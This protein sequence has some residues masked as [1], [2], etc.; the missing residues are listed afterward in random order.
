[1]SVWE[2]LLGHPRALAVVKNAAARPTGSYLLV[3]APGG[4]KRNAARVLA[5]ALICPEGCG[6]CN[7]CSRVLRDLH[8]DVTVLQPEGYTFAVE[9]LRAAAAAAA[10]TP[11]EAAHR[12]FLVEEADRIP[13]RTQNALLKA[14]EEPNA[15]VV[16]ILLA[17]STEAF[18]PTI[19]SRCQMIDFPPVAEEALAK[20]L[21]SR[22]SMS[23]QASHL[24][25]RAS[26]G[27]LDAAVRL[28]EDTPADALRRRALQ[29]C[30]RPEPSGA[31]LLREAD[32]I[33]AL[34]TSFR[35]AADKKLTAEIADFEKVAGPQT[36]AWRKRMLD[37]NKRVLRRLE[38][39]V[40]IDYLSWLGGAFRDLAAASSGA[41][42][43][44][45]I[46]HDFVEGLQ[47]AS[48]SHGTGFWIDMVERCLNG[49]LAI[50]EN[51]NPTLVTESILLRLVGFGSSAEGLP[52]S[53]VRRR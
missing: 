13:E 1:M 34:A 14:L 11:L 52:M 47:G 20:L 27:D 33:K 12:V 3:G 7:A 19:V 8:P 22:Y 35:D 39:E 18:L 23:E 49:Q 9:A 28:A 41:P 38:T 24:H 15:S 44:A 5:A 53:A 30:V 32:A 43:D 2:G 48:R 6:E 16:W 17:S 10:Q 29:V 26:R 4:G 42:Q 36:G 21:R 50:K 46:A 31:A 45:L 37:R 25:I 40:F 51:A